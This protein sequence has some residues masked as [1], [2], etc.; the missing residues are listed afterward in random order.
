M[1]NTWRHSAMG[2]LVCSMNQYRI[3]HNL[4]LQILKRLDM[5]LVMYADIEAILKKQ[6]VTETNTK[7]THRHMPAA[8]GNIVMSRMPDNELHGKYV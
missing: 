6:D 7:K 8:I 1:R 3:H 5:P 4:I 2:G